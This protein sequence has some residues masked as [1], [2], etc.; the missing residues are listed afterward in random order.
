MHVSD[1]WLNS[2]P[3]GK[4]LVSYLETTWSSYKMYYFYIS[5]IKEVM[6]GWYVEEVGDRECF[7]ILAG[8]PS[9]RFQLGRP[10]RWEGTIK[11]GLS[12]VGYEDQRL[13]ELG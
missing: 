1:W 3:S 12:E 7:Q 5:K 11:L 10:W 8:K 13:M 6:V 4:S 9:A 2:E